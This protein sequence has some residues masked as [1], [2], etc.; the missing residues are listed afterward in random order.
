[1]RHCFSISYVLLFCVM[2]MYRLE[3][4]IGFSGASPILTSDTSNERARR[5]ESGKITFIGCKQLLKVVIK[6]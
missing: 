6:D 1:M 3:E 2:V 4:K 5:A